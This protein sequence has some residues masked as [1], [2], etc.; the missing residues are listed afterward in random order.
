MYQELWND[1]TDKYSDHY[2]NAENSTYYNDPLVRKKNL[3]R[4]YTRR[5]NSAGLVLV[6]V[7][8]IAS[9]ILICYVIFVLFLACFKLAKGES[10]KVYS[11]RQYG[12]NMQSESGN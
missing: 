6:T 10:Y 7:F 8:I 11:S 1:N 3:L 12:V 9:I 4:L 2:L 5:N